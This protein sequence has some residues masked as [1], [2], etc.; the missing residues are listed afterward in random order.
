MHPCPRHAISTNCR[1]GDIDLQ[2]TNDIQKLNVF[3]T[4]NKHNPFSRM[5][6]ANARQPHV[7]TVTEQFDR[8]EMT[9][10][11]IRSDSLLIFSAKSHDFGCV[12]STDSGRIRLSSSETLLLVQLP[13]LQ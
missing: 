4:Q 5:C 10:E 7:N 1:S 9:G 12:A 2:T 3:Q 11:K 8:R 6:L 13:D